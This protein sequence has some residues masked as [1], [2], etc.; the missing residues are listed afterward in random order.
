M[1]FGQRFGSVH[2]LLYALLPNKAGSTYRNLFTTIRPLNGNLAPALFSRDYEIAIITEFLRA[3]PNANIGGCLFHLSQN[4]QK[5]VR[6]LHLQQ[7]YDNDA[8][9]NLHVRMIE[10]LAFIPPDN[11]IEAF[12][13]LE[14]YVD[15]SLEPLVEYFEDNYIGRRH[16]RGR[17]TPRFKIEWWN[18]YERT[19]ALEPWTNNNAEAGFRR[20]QSEFGWAHPTF[21]KFIRGIQGQHVTRDLRV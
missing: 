7:M 18:V 4:I 3:F 13:V 1:I 5:H 12:E 15:V 6:E 20:L 10:A 16:R 19:L 21:W 8:R 17:K 9:I 11:V 2:P 14:E